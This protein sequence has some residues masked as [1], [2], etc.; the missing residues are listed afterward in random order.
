VDDRSFTKTATAP[1][2]EVR[3]GD[4]ERQAAARQLQ[5]H[6]ADGRLSWE[7]LD[8][9]L[10][11]AYAAR[12]NAE[13][14]GLFTDLP[15]LAPPPPPPAPRRSPTQVVAAQL[16]NL[17]IRRTVLLVLAAA[18]A[19]GVTRGLV[20]PIV[21]IWW[22]AAGRHRHHGQPRRHQHPRRHHHHGSHHHGNAWS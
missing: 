17:D 10:A 14:T 12:V 3:I 2:L 13:L 8:E 5:Q 1:S 6:F 15:M 21:L 7:E 16:G 11:V 9:R 18:V 20:I 19:I 22:F 4:V